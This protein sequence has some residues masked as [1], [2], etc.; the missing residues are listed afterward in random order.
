MAALIVDG[1]YVTSKEEPND[2]DL[3][4]ALRTDF[5]PAGE[6]RPFEYNVLSKPNAK[7]IGSIS[8]MYVL[9]WMEVLSTKRKCSSSVG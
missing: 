4:I 9:Q 6:L 7:S 1:S 8:S 3:I 5:E 2:I